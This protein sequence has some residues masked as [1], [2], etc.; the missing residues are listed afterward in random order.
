[1]S[2]EL[3]GRRTNQPGPPEWNI[4][5]HDDGETVFFDLGF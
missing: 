2:W 3:I 5:L 4:A 1:M